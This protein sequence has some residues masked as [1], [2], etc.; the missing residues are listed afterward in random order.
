[1]SAIIVVKE[2]FQMK[3]NSNYFWDASNWGQWTLLIVFVI[4]TI[5]AFQESPE[6]NNW[7]FYLAAVGESLC[8][9]K[10]QTFTLTTLAEWTRVASYLGYVVLR[11]IPHYFPFCFLQFGAFLA[12]VLSLREIA[13]FPNCG[14]YAAILK[15]VR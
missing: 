7:Q 6:I 9:G 14:I 8:W 3:N 11:L 13:K 12:W 10:C 1:M 4:N 5:P 2:I 15:K